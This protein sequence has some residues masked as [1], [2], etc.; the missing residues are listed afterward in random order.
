M[1][2]AAEQ[3]EHD[4]RPPFAHEQPARRPQ[5]R[6]HERQEQRHRDRPAPEGERRRRHQVGEHPADDP[7]AGPE[8]R[9]EREQRV[10]ER[11][12]R[13]GTWPE[14][15]PN[16]K[17]G[18]R[19]LARPVTSLDHREGACSKASRRRGSIPARRRSACGAAAAARR[20][21]CSHGNPQTHAMWHKVAPRLAE[22]FTVIA[23]DLRGYGESGKPPVHARPRPLL[24]ARDGA[25]PGRG[26][27]A[28]RARALLR[29]RPR[30]RRARRLSHGARSS[31]RGCTSSRCST[32]SPRGRRSGAPTWRS[33]SATG[34]GSSSP[35]RRTCRRCCIGADPDEYW[36]RHT[37]REPK[38]RDFFAAGGARRIPALLPRP[39]DASTRS[40]R[41]IAPP[42]PS[43]A[44]TTRRTARRAGASAARCSRSGASK[45][46]LEA[47]YDVLAVWRDWADDVR[48]RAL[49]CGHYVPEEAPEETYAEFRTFFGG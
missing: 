2:P 42:R 27:A 22:H 44:R 31:G 18:C 32:S 21:S 43:T 6:S 11:R 33:A 29:R 19:P 9:G 12:T 23:T 37:A 8:Q 28:A 46:R 16:R 39:R 20:C 13:A 48:G 15:I 17:S 34:T 7:V 3:A 41:T 4:D 25:R 5:A 47:W 1:Q 26:D 10:G 49:P 38:P 30:P 36:F 45:G 35:S 14:G 24:Q 40:A